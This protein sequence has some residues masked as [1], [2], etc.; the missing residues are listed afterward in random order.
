MGLFLYLEFGFTLPVVLYAVYR[1]GL[2][3]FYGRSSGTSGLDELVFLVYG[4][5]TAFTTLVCFH[6][7]FYWDDTLYSAELKNTFKY[8]FF[9]PW[10]V[11]RE[12]PTYLPAYLTLLLFVTMLMTW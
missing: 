12:S 10:I 1:L 2:S 7:V 3:S 8:N 9:G 4:F 6:D 11:M 5:E